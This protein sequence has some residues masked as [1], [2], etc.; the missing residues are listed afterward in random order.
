[1]ITKAVR[2]HISSDVHDRLNEG[3]TSGKIMRRKIVGQQMFAPKLLQNHHRYR[4]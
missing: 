1:M 2:L 4:Q 3:S